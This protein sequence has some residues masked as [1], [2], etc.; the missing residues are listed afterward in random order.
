MVMIF[1]RMLC[2]CRYWYP[3]FMCLTLNPWQMITQCFLIGNFWFV[4]R[5][6][7]GEPTLSLDAAL[8]KMHL[9]L[10]G[11]NPYPLPVFLTFES[12]FLST[13]IDMNF[14]NFLS[15]HNLIVGGHMVDLVRTFWF[16]K[17]KMSYSI[18]LDFFSFQPSN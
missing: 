13:D 18:K 16:I 5:L 8:W 15:I 7:L 4:S 17:Y 6:I 11:Y 1:N 9:W 12:P 2:L 10:W 14:S 3:Q